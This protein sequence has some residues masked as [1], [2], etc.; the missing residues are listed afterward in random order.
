MRMTLSEIQAEVKNRIFDN[1]GLIIGEPIVMQEAWFYE[2]TAYHLL[3]G[4]YF[5]TKF[6]FVVSVI[7]KTRNNGSLHFIPG[8]FDVSQV[9]NTVCEMVFDQF[10]ETSFRQKRR[11]IMDC[12]KLIIRLIKQID[13]IELGQE[14]AEEI[15]FKIKFDHCEMLTDVDWI[16]EKMREM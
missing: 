1:Q 8:S 13:A 5:T 2:Q 6:N 14:Q 9:R 16:E 3:V 12:G 11:I 15:D 7:N 4:A 10:D